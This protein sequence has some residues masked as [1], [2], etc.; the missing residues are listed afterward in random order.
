MADNKEKFLKLLKS[1]NR[2]G[3]DKLIAWLEKS[4]FFKDP[5]SSQFHG[6]YEG[7]L[8]QHS[9][10][11]YEELVKLCG[12]DDDTVKIS[13]LLHDIC[14][15]G[16]YSVDYKNV[17]NDLGVW[18]KVP[19]YKSIS[20]GFPYGHG[21]KSV[22]M[23]SQFINLTIEEVMAIRWHMGAYESKECWKDL[24]EAQK[25]YPLA[26]YIHFADMIASQLRGA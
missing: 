4:S 12:R 1:V 18:E 17:K 13:A 11:V 15:T 10:T 26:L 2:E 24:G 8:C 14:K 21:E 22:Y 19:Y 9:L 6:N 5:A 7:G 20:N 16:T 3:M 23:L 25:Q